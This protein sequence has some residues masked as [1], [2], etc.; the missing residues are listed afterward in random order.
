MIWLP[1][2]LVSIVGYQVFGALGW[3]MI[4]RYCCLI[5][6]VIVVVVI[7]VMAGYERRQVL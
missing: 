2:R 3:L 6:D 7:V 1:C 4:I 5:L